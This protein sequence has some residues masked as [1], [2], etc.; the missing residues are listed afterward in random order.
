MIIE[1]DDRERQLLEIADDYCTIR[2]SQ[3]I[4][5][6]LLTGDVAIWVSGKLRIVIE[7]K[8][9][10]DLA[11]SIKDQRI[12]TQMANFANLRLEIP[13][14]VLIVIVEGTPA[15][16]HYGIKIQNLMTKLDHLM[17]RDGIH[18]MFTRDVPG[19]MSRVTQLANNLPA[20]SESATDDRPDIL[21][22]KHE[23]TDDELL[24][25]MYMQIPQVSRST[26]KVLFAMKYSII[27][28]FELD[29]SD[30]VKLT[31]PSGTA[32]PLKRARKITSA[33][34]T[35]KCWTRILAEIPGVSSKIAQK[36][37]DE[38][39]LCYDWTAEHISQIQRSA[40]SR[41]GMKCAERVVHLINYRPL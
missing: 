21:Q 1:I 5:K 2:E 30:I 17:L 18:V 24:M 12:E 15:R 38:Y 9:W 32:I 8:T 31:Y 26:A 22:S 40:K 27:D 13:T 33:M 34:A 20:S 37:M 19:T 23:K 6:R 36:I 11:Q 4:K 35:K 7:R 16:E 29:T 39:P 41:L 10:D 14:C 28:V 3:I 25:N